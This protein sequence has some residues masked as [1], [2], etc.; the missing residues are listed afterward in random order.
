MK[1][2]ILGSGTSSGVPVISC[3]CDTCLSDDTR[4]KRLRCS[5]LIEIGDTNIVVDTSP[6]FRQQMLRENVNKLDAVIY[7]HHH[8]DHIGGFDDIRAFNF[9]TRK[10]FNIYANKKTLSNLKRAFVYAFEPPE[11]IGG[12]IPI[13]NVHEID[14]QPFHINEIKVEPIKVFHGKLEV[15]AYRINNFA[16]VTDTNY[17]P[18]DSIE[19]LKNLDVLILDALRYESHPTHFN[20]EQALEMVSILKPKKTYLTHIAHQIK[21]SELENKLP[22]NVEIAFDGIKFEV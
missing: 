13:I 8:F 2:T 22:K 17:I 4:D 12:G 1:V 7:T 10:A 5:I 16:Y 6:D 21:H 3:R 20:V 19:K 11:Q 14:F 18:E 15:I 9:T